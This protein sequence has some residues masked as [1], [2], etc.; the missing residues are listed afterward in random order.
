MIRILF[1]LP[2]LGGGG[3]ERVLV[4][5][6]NHM[7]QDKF[8]ITVQTLFSGGVNRELL[9]EKIRYL[10]GHFPL[11]RGQRI[12][13]KLIPP[14]SLF[15]RYIK[16]HYDVMV[17]YMH[18]AATKVI[19]GSPRGQKK[20]AWL[21][22]ETYDASLRSFFF[23][24]R[25]MMQ[26]LTRYHAVVGVSKTIIESFR[27]RTGITEHTHVR[28]NTNDVERVVRLSRET[29]ELPFLC[30]EEPVVCTVGNLRFV[31]GYDRLLRVCKRLFDEGKLFKLII[32]GEGKER[33]SLQ[34]YINKNQMGNRIFLLGFQA[35]PY[36]Y[37]RN[38][39]FF[40]CSSRFEGL[41]TA[42][43]EAMILGIPV[44]STEVSGAKEILGG[45]SEYG[46]IVGNTEEALYEGVKRFLSEEELIKQYKAAA[47]RRKDFFS[48]AD[49]VRSVEELI[50]SI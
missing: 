22:S 10:E 29:P 9:H 48:V 24:R 21:H 3:A 11:K 35:N 27:K 6:V 41:S 39:D 42:V 12:F 18:G 43:S 4:N 37:L 36:S 7:D 1:L 40:I 2:N 44:V 38:S 45:S 8:E 17:A 14:R 46:L 28:Y 23:S 33:K 19:A 47:I 30:G 5:L 31:K 25:A 16:E 20:I 15:R 49:T 13:I 26:S 32:I 34:K 50:T